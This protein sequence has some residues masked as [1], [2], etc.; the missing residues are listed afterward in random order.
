ML[1]P[2]S[3]VNAWQT[4]TLA[5]VELLVNAACRVLYSPVAAAF[6]VVRVSSQKTVNAFLVMQHVQLVSAKE[7][8]QAALQA[9][10]FTRVLASD[11]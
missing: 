1:L 4:A 8:A 9:R 11:V 2:S 10:T 7:P 3:V 5:R 6:H